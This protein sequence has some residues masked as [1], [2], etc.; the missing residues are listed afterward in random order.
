MF[1]L[2]KLGYF[3][4]FL[5]SVHPV[6]ACAKCQIDWSH[7]PLLHW[8]ARSQTLVPFWS[9]F[10]TRYIREWS[11][12]S[13][14]YSRVIKFE[15]ENIRCSLIWPMHIRECLLE[16]H[17]YENAQMWAILVGASYIIE[18]HVILVN[19][20]IWDKHIRSRIFCLYGMLCSL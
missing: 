8:S 12:F 3:I 4:F 11:N 6:K 17:I 18:C 20:Q 14:I 16:Q 19:A 5:G 2:L 13:I 7:H 9:W 10:W 15:L 1:S